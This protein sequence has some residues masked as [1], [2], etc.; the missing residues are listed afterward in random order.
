[1]ALKNNKLVKLAILDDYQN[2][3]LSS[4]DWSSIQDKC[5]I[6][7]FHQHLGDE[8]NIIQVL[9]EYTI[10]CCMR[11]RTPFPESTL[12]QLPNLRLL[13][14]TGSKNAAIDMGAAKSLDIIVLGTESPGHAAAELAWALLMSLAKNI[15]IDNQDIRGNQWQANIGTDLKGQTLGVVGLGRHGTNVVRFA[16]AFGMSCIAWSQN[17]TQ[18]H[19]ESLGVQYVDK[20]TLFRTSDF[21]SIHLKMGQRNKGLIERQEFEWMKPSAFLINTSRGPIINESALLNALSLKSIAGA[22]LDV[23]DIEPW[24]KSHTLFYFK[25]VLLTPHTGYVTRQTYEVFYGQVV[26]KINAWLE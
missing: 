11:E 21:I 5:D 8:N 4:A 26:E 3:A 23:Y 1:M 9:S 15:H 2:V 22:G 20:E 6:T 7:I 16:Q 24:P 17:L 12:K 19:C 18:E 13:L 14:T 10:I 25:N